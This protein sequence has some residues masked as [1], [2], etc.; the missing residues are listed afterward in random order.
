MAQ[1]H[2]GSQD[3]SNLEFAH[4]A[5][6]Q[7]MAI[8]QAEPEDD[9]ALQYMANL[10]YERAMGIA[11]PEEKRQQLARAK[12]WFEELE[13]DVPRNKEAPFTLGVMAW[14]QAHSEWLSAR[15]KAGMNAADPGPLKDSAS[16]A[17]LAARCGP[18][19]EES[20]KHL[21]HA[22]EIDPDFANAMEYLSMVLRERAD[23][24]SGE[25]DYRRQIAEAQEWARKAVEAR[26]HRSRAAESDQ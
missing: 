25:D 22:L 9:T 21:R 18:S 19:W 12:G 6:T 8:L 14:Q 1:F 3:P 2:T 16:R 24:A 13:K 4:K 20:A 11:D 7:F 26:Q 5:E 23:I 17:A 15:S 10:S